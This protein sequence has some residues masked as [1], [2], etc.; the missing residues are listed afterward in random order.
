MTLN[1]SGNSTKL[2]F[3]MLAN[4]N[5]EFIQFDASGGS[6][7]IGSGT[8]EKAD[9]TAYGT[10]KIIGDYALAPPASITQ[11][12]ALPSKGGLLQTGQAHWQ[13]L[14][15]ISTAMAPITR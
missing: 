8:M 6:G 13:Q 5:A 2:A 15:E 12:I 11:I 14:R 7:I 9:T 1:F 3:A 4:G 10:T